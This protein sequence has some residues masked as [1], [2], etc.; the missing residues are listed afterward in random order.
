MDRPADAHRRGDIV[1]PRWFVSFLSFTVSVVF[2]GAVL[3]AWQIS[4]D[5]SAIKV[6]VRA[7]TDLRRA[8]LDDIRRRLSRHDLLLERLL[9]RP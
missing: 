8:E 3:W 5:V 4:T 9:E 2:M 6:E 1:V 7:Q